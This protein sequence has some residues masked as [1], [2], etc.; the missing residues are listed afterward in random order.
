MHQDHQL[1]AGLLIRCV[2]QLELIQTIDNIVFFP[3][4]SRKEDAENLAQAQAEALRQRLS[5]DAQQREDQGMY[6]YL[7]TTQLFQLLDCLM[8]SH[9]F[10]KRFNADHDQR[11]LLWRAGEDE[12]RGCE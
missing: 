4:T 8:Q 7:S 11:N 2:V 6:P 10:A 12:E 1:F 5:D 3:T 9:R